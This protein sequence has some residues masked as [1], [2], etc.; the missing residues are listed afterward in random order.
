MLNISPGHPVTPHAHGGTQGRRQQ[1]ANLTAP[2]QRIGSQQANGKKSR[3]TR[4]STGNNEA[5][6]EGIFSFCVISSI[7][8]Q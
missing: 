7:Y 1:Q 3:T 2:A 6:G 5:S 4:T 8:V